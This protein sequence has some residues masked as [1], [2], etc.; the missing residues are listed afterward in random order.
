MG[1]EEVEEGLWREILYAVS[2]F[3]RYLMLCGWIRLSGSP[4]ASLRECCCR[5]AGR[6]G[7]PRALRLTE[8]SLAEATFA[9]SILVSCRVRYGP[10][11]RQ[12]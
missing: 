11:A 12:E 10:V 3:V 8:R 1:Y 6:K 9:T 4:V 7:S 2:S 5:L